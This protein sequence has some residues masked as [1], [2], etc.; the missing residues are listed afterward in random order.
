[1]HLWVSAPITIDAEG[2]ALIGKIKGADG[3]LATVLKAML[4]KEKY[5]A[6]NRDGTAVAGK[7]NVSAH[8]VLTPTRADDYAITLNNIV[9]A[10]LLRRADPPRYP[11]GMARS[12]VS[13]HVTLALTVASDGKVIRAHS[14]NASDASF[15]KEVLAVAE[16]WRFE[17][18]SVDGS[19]FEYEVTLPIFFN[20]STQRQSHKFS[21]GL[22]MRG[23]RWIKQTEGVCLDLLEIRL[24]S[25]R[26]N[27]AQ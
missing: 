13:G 24:G 11:L 17:S 25:E 10:P 2:S 16:R 5:V 23:P 15:S 4:E 9:V 19:N 18:A 8:A 22:D 3:G 27:S 7:M 12:G 20:A 26:T 14:V 1:M 6:A 21:C